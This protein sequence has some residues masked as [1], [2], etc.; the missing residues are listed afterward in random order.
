MSQKTVK[1]ADVDID[2]CVACGACS[3]ACPRKAIS[4]FR[5]CFANVKTDICVGCGKC[6]KV[7]PAGCISI[8]EQEASA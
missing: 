2:H 1:Y 5:G 7:C 3:Q 4:V 6:S 8:R